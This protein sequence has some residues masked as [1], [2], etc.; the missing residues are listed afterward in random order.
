MILIKTENKKKNQHIMQY[1]S[2]DDGPLKINILHFYRPRVMRNE[3][4]KR[5]NI[6]DV[7][8]FRLL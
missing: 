5:L 4:T 7:C 2:N 1:K 8:I 6:L 3:F